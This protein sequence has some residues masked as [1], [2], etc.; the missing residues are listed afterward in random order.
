MSIRKS[1]KRKPVIKNIVTGFRATPAEHQ[2]LKE[3][4]SSENLCVSK[5]LRKIAFSTHNQKAA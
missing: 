4:A 1:R 2:L 3:L 5:F